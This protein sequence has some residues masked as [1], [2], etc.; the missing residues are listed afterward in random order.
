MKSQSLPFLY[1]ASSNV[2]LSDEEMRR[3]RWAQAVRYWRQA[4]GREFETRT[5]VSASVASGDSGVQLRG[6]YLVRST[7]KLISCGATCTDGHPL[8][9]YQTGIYAA[10]ASHISRHIHILTV[11]NKSLWNTTVSVQMSL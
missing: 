6:A 8:L 4:S 10:V 3:R 9:R 7:S 5:C 2:S 11:L 1:S